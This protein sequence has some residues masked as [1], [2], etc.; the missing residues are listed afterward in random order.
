MAITVHFEH[1]GQPMAM[2]L[3][4]VEV[5]RSHSG[6]NLAEDEDEPL[7]AWKYGEALTDEQR[8]ERDDTHLAFLRPENVI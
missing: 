8:E 3:D 7:N 2:L 4:L 6:A 5:P 1:E